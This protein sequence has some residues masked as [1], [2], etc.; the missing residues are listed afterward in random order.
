MAVDVEE[1]TALFKKACP[2]VEFSNG[3]EARALNDLGV[4]SLDMA[5][6]LLEVQE[7]FGVVIPDEE[8]PRL[9]TIAAITSYVAERVQGK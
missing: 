6:A 8:L 7:R 3:D 4:D 1:V 5:N 9:Q 2:G